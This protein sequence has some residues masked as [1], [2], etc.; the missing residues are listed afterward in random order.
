MKQQIIQLLDNLQVKY[1]WLNHPAVYTVADLNNLPDNIKPI[2]NLLV[3]EEGGGQKFLMVMAGDKRLD[4][5]VIKQYLKNKR[6]RFAS[7]D[8]L[9]ETLGATSGSVSI[10]SFLNEG[11]KDVRVIVD[12]EIL[13]DDEVGFHPNENTA[14]V[15]FASK[16]LESILQKMGCDYTII[17][18]Y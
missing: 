14:T 10:F 1:R 9:M 6:L 5:K 4:Q 17:K 12:Q 7:D 3:Q 18:L 13:K 16:N 2:K 15:F 11:S 8:S